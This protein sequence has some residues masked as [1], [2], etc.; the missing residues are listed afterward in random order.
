M[1]DPWKMKVRGCHWRF[2]G[3]HTT[4]CRSLVVTV[5][6]FQGKW[7]VF[8]GIVFLQAQQCLIS[9]RTPGPLALKYSQ[10][11][12][13]N[14]VRTMRVKTGTREDLRMNVRPCKVLQIAKL[15]QKNSA[16]NQF[17]KWAQNTDR[18][19]LLSKPSVNG[20]MT[21]GNH[22]GTCSIQH[23]LSVWLLGKGLEWAS[24]RSHKPA[25]IW[26]PMIGT[27]C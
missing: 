5:S 4:R 11:G 2:D 25:P 7:Q 22:D 16:T 15:N 23:I 8:Q 18:K 24:L 6:E 19:C 12:T 13:T 3:R 1:Y 20:R 21:W 17:A 9:G 14:R 27:I 26:F 10:P